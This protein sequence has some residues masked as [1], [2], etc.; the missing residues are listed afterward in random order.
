ML[1]EMG[2]GSMPLLTVGDSDSAG[3]A[4]ESVRLMQQDGI[5]EVIYRLMQQ[6]G[7]AEAMYRLM[8]QDG[9]AEAM[10]RLMQQ[11]SIA[12]AMYRLMQQDSIAEV[13]KLRDKLKEDAKAGA[14]DELDERIYLLKKRQRQNQR[15]AAAIERI[16]AAS[17]DGRLIQ[18]AT[19]HDLTAAADEA[20]VL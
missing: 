14:V 20:V 18:D 1:G 2:V 4:D 15:Q 9:I 8:Q 13:G 7:I 12:E 11:D 5:A 10:Y 3:E 19:A 16:I 17:S 6:D